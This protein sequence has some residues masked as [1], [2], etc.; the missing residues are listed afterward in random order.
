MGP[1]PGRRYLF[2]TI[3]LF[4]IFS[5]N[6]PNYIYRVALALYQKKRLP[7]Y[8]HI[9]QVPKSVE[10]PHHIK[11]IGFGAIVLF[12]LVIAIFES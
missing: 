5:C 3:G 7:S 8:K 11:L 4:I 2:E 1:A 12:F 6:L 10:K 9:F